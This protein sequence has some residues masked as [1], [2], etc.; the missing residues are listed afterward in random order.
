MHT[1]T[2]TELNVQKLKM[3]SL[4]EGIN[5]LSPSQGREGES[6]RWECLGCNTG[7]RREE[8]RE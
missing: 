2:H 8:E 3:I 1:R 4:L 5:V 6:W 7:K